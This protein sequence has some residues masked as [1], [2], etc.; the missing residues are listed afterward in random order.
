MSKRVTQRKLVTMSEERS[1]IVKNEGIVMTMTENIGMTV[2][3]GSIG[4]VIVNDVVMM[5]MMHGLGIET[6]AAGD[7]IEM[8]DI[9]KMVL[10]AEIVSTDIA[11]M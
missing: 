4:M 10:R 2:K 1:D 8:R 6:T 11:V 9:G 3:R 5:T 7:T